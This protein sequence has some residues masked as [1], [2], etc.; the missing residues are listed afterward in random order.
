MIPVG[1]L[2]PWDVY[3]IA[4]A[5]ADPAILAIANTTNNSV[6]NFNGD[7]AIALMRSDNTYVDVIGQIGLDP[8]TAWIS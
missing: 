6:I 2:N 1:V 8:G 3:V 7:D 5:S 4:H